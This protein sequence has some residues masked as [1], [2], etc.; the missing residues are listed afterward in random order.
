[1]QGFLCGLLGTLQGSALLLQQGEPCSEIAAVLAPADAPG[2]SDTGS[3][4][5]DTSPPALLSETLLHLHQAHAAWSAA[6]TAP[7]GSAAALRASHSLLAAASRD[8][9]TCK[10]VPPSPQARTKLNDPFDSASDYRTGQGP[11]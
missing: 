4:L 9:E 8:R 2:P 11:N 7:R 3:T 5:V 10:V 6:A 1:M